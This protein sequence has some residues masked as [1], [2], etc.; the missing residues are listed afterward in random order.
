MDI[1]IEIGSVFTKILLEVHFHRF[2]IQI[3]YLIDKGEKCT[4]RDGRWKK[5]LS[6]NHCEL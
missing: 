5:L 1:I 3:L 6:I 4:G 2:N